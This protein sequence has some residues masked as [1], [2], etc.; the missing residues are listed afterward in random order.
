VIISDAMGM[1]AITNNYGFEEAI[2]LAVL[3]GT[4]ILLYTGNQYNGRSL[5]AEVTR[6]IRQNIDAN[7][8][9]EARIDASYDRIMT[10]KNKIPVSVIPSPYVPETP[11]LISAFPNPFNNTVRIRLSVNRHIYESV[12][13]RIYSSSGQLIRHVDLSV[14]GHG[15]YEIAWDG[16]SA[17]GKA[18]S[19]GIYIYT[20]E[21][22]GRY[23]SGKMALL[24]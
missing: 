16:T 17:D 4:D 9:S 8:L 2:V 11:F 24:K 1:G 12:P 14:R 10:L 22:N 3:A 20:A 13:L 7:I 6:I 18:V 5:V 21:I 15:D 19:S 23:V